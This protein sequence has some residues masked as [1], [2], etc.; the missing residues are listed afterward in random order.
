MCLLHRAVSLRSRQSLSKNFPTFY[1]TRKFITMLTRA[2]HWSLSWARLIQSM[3][4]HL[5]L[6]R[7]ILIFCHDWFF[8]ALTFLL[9]P[10]PKS[11][12]HSASS[13]ARYIPCPSH[14][15]YIWRVQVMKLFVTQFSLSSYHFISLRSKYSPQHPVLKRPK[16]VFLPKVRDEVSHPFKA[17]DKIIS[18]YVPIFTFSDSRRED[19]RF[20]TEW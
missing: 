20:Q 16:P 6:L 11:C 9:A 14:F 8:L 13:D 2:L 15:N 3:P 17:T 10:T 4:P 7:S 12:M 19:R 5:I 1:G 18:L